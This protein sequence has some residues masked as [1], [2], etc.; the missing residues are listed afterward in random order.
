MQ[1]EKEKKTAEQRFNDGFIEEVIQAVKSNNA[2]WQQ[3]WSSGG[4][5]VPY[6]AQ[7]NKFYSGRNA[8]RL[9]LKAQKQGYQDPR[10]ATALQINSMNGR[11][12]KGEKGTGILFF[13]QSLVKD[14]ETGE[15]TTKSIIKHATVFNIEQTNLPTLT[16]EELRENTPDIEAFAKLI[17]H[18]QP[19]ILLGEPAYHLNNDTIYMPEKTA[20][21]T[22]ADYYATALHEMS[23]W[24][25]HESRLNRDLKNRLNTP[26]YAREELVAELSSYLLS[27]EH[28]LPFTPN[29][30]EAYLKHWA[31]RTDQ[32]LGEAL[33]LAFKEAL[34]AKNY[35]D[36]PLREKRL[37]QS[38][39]QTTETRQDTQQTAQI[40]PVEVEKVDKAAEAESKEEK[41][42][43]QKSSETKA[44]AEMMSASLQTQP[45]EV[46]QHFWQ[47]FYG[48]INEQ[49]ALNHYMQ[50]QRIYLAV[51][52]AEREQAKALG[53]KWD[54]QNGCWYADNLDEHPSLA[55]Y[56][57]KTSEYLGVTYGGKTLDDF[58]ASAAVLGLQTA[59]F[60][61]EIGKWH[62]VPLQGRSASNKDGAYKLFQNA[63]GTLGGIAKNLST[64][65][66]INWS[67]RV[68]GQKIPKEIQLSN[69]L[70]SHI[71]QNLS[72][73]V[74][75]EV[76]RERG[77][78]ALALY[79]TLENAHGDEPYL[80]RKQM[81]SIHGIKRLDDGSI[82]IPLINGEAVGALK[83]VK[84]RHFSLVSL[85]VILPV[86]QD[87]KRLMRQAQK[88]GAYFPIGTQA[89]RENPTHVILAEGVATAEASHQIFSSIADKNSRVLAIAA[90]DSGNLAAVAKTLTELYPDAQKIIAA[91]N[92]RAT[93]QKMGKNTGI[94]AA[95]HV[96][97]H[98]ADFQLA[99]PQALD[100]RNTDW[101]DVLVKQGKEI[102]QHQF[103]EQL[104]LAAKKTQAPITASI[105]LPDLSLLCPR[106]IGK[107]A[108]EAIAGDMNQLPQ[109][110][111]ALAQHGYH[112]DERHLQGAKHPLEMKEAFNKAISPLHSKRSAEQKAERTQ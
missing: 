37:E 111:T 49:E 78:S 63:D 26:Q 35:L 22:D 70:N 85:Q 89:A 10:W 80:Q 48:E 83:D 95:K 11:I 109:L 76:Q 69:E 45:D 86:E 39:E 36:A 25:G 104:R 47:A 98:Y 107:M 23:H 108:Y 90:I 32:E 24:T 53:A 102:A 79:K 41:A 51:S 97:A 17:E 58:K 61:T 84:N 74:R 77:R 1:A 75:T 30:S 71:Q 59:N 110:K 50:S 73:Q 12:N 2:P 65:E 100:G 91:D 106:D 14:L 18:H 28:G 3:S 87:N 44:Q 34:N 112:F 7:S 62:R 20:F 16:R 57:I 99:I 92:D 6:N 38:K 13:S 68:A 46:T 81:Q 96:K 60:N 33:R 94:E 67:D 21:A 64:G 55:Q 29:Q 101:N 66:S 103:S 9:A 4:M 27:L 72:L 56:M 52:Y 54:G 42:S 19:R 93:A 40:Q 31:E 88:L 8:I 105:Q 82:V 5:F 15:E 43:E